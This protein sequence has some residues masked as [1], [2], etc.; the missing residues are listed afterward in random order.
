M[1]EARVTFYD[2]KEFGFYK[3]GGTHLFGDVR[4]LLDELQAWCSGKTISETKTYEVGQSAQV[5]PAYFLSLRQVRGN[6]LLSLWNETSSTEGAVA[7]ISQTAPVGTT[8]VTMNEIEEGSIP[9]VATYF[10]FVPAS[11]VVATVRFQHPGTGVPQMRTYLRRFMEQFSSYAV[12]EEQD[13]ELVT[14]GFRENASSETFVKARARIALVPHRREAERQFILDRAAQIRRI[15]KKGVL[16]LTTREDRAI[17]QRFLDAFHVDEPAVRPHEVKMSFEVEVD[18]LT[19]E[20][21][22]AVMGNYDEEDG[23]NDYGFKFKGEGSQTHWLGKEIAHDSVDVDVRRLNPEMVN[24]E[25]L[26]GELDRLRTR[27]LALL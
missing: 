6:F 2:L 10:W 21:V 27:L 9:G 8:R 3:W 23:Q 19:R 18:G 1:E 12:T 24:P 20:E 15:E 11:S 16:Q 17:W 7:S 5:L 26:A 25:D 4:A 14:T 13:G 22:E